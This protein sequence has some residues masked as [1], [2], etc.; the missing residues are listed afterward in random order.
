MIILNKRNSCPKNKK[1]ADEKDETCRT[2]DQLLIDK[3]VKRLQEKA[4]QF[5]YGMDRL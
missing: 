4:Q 2:K 5:I 1:D 3:T